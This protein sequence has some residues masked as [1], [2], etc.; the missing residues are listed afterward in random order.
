MKLMKILKITA[1]ATMITAG[2]FMIVKGC[3]E[4][5]KKDAK[6]KMILIAKQLNTDIKN[7]ERKTSPCYHKKNQKKYEELWGENSGCN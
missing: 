2:I 3:M 4:K 1:Y 6:E 5:R 7:T